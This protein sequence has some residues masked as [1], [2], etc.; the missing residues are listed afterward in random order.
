M[1]IDIVFIDLHDHVVVIIITT[2]VAFTIILIN[3]VLLVYVLY[4]N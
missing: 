4:L 2:I 3:I 1:L